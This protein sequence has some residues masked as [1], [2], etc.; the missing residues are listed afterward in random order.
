[1]PTK[2]QYTGQ[3]SQMD[4]IGL[5][6]FVARWADPLTGHFV[7][8]DTIVPSAGNVKDFNRYAYG[9]L[10][11]P[12]GMNLTQRAQRES[13]I[14]EFAPSPQD[15]VVLRSGGGFSPQSTPRSQ[16]F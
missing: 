13:I 9:Q 15:F 5:M 7:Q 12:R 8:A 14:A 3:L 1:M 11:Q 4:E 16:R 2:Y 6:Y 10:H